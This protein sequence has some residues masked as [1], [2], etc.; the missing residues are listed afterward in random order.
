MSC[1]SAWRRSRSSWTKVAGMGR[2]KIGEAATGGVSREGESG[3]GRPN[4]DKRKR[5]RK[6]RRARRWDE[7][8]KERIW[9]I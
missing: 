5:K 1:F 9:E 2:S 8:Q 6:R 3:D 4:E 7:E